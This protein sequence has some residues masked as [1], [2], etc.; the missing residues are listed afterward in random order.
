MRNR[1]EEST[2][3]GDMFVEEVRSLKMRLQNQSSAI[4]QLED[5][6][7]RSEND[8]R[9]ACTKHVAA[10]RNTIQLEEK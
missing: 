1:C 3:V 5:I 6:A 7:T 8:A 10:E 2:K 9:E 4:A